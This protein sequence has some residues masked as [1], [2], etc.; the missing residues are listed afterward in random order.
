MNILR[1]EKGALTLG[2]IIFILIVAVGGYVGLKMAIPL[3]RNQQAKEV[4]RN[5]VER[6]KQ[7]QKQMASEEEIRNTVHNKLDEI[8]VKLLPDDRSD[9][10][11]GLVIILEEGKPAVMEAAFKMDVNFI[12]GYK[13]TY[14][15]KIRKVAKQ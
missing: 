10:D 7:V 11:D 6:M 1:S 4:L 5:E 9:Y 12:G 2:G 3:V 14:N 13:Y 15:F 8:G